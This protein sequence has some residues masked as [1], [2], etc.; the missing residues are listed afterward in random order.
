HENSLQRLTGTDRLVEDDLAE[1]KHWVSIAI[2]GGYCV[3]RY[4][5]SQRLGLMASQ[6]LI[7][8]KFIVIGASHT[9]MIGL[10]TR[11]HLAIDLGVQKALDDHI[12]TMLE[13]ESRG[14]IHVRDVRGFRMITD[15]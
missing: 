10:Q 2:P 13:R 14:Q 3:D 11:E 9:A 8:S 5:C 12:Q 4:F 15:V 7:Q 6:C 1:C